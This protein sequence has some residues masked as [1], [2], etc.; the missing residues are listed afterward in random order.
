MSKT[1]K[2]RPW[3]IAYDDPANRRFRM[4]GCFD[5]PT[6]DGYEWTWK[7]IVSCHDS[8][9]C[10]G[11]WYK[12][13]NRKKRALLRSAMRDALKTSPQDREDID[14]AINEHLW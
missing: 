2:T 1:D 14:I 11:D 3:Q 6:G 13:V 9:C 8:H 4:I 7:K 10:Y 12:F 5:Y